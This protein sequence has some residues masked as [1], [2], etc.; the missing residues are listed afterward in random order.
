MDTTTHTLNSN[1]ANHQPPAVQLPAQEPETRLVVKKQPGQF[2]AVLAHEVRNT[3]TNINLS[4]ELLSTSVHA[5]E[6]KIYQDIIRRNVLRINNLIED[7][8]RYQSADESQDENHSVI[9]LLDEVLEMTEDSLRLKNIK[10]LKEYDAEDCT[11]MMNKLKMKIALTNIIVNAIEA[12]N[13]EQGEL[14][15][16][17][18]NL[19]TQYII[20]IQDNGCGISQENLQQIY[21]PYYT[22]KPGGLGLGLATTYNI[23]RSNHIVINVE[24][25]EGKG[26][27]FSLV[28]ERI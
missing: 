8:L 14:K 9:K 21:M 18:R 13:A 25:E 16:V 4:V 27:C 15:L 3:L 2:A 23:L 7:L 28:L 24:S 20:L 6:L 12:M 5:N 22:N 17:T 19:G 10:V 11:I 1:I 26:T